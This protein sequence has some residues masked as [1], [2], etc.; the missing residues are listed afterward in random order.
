MLSQSRITRDPAFKLHN[1]NMKVDGWFS[2]H[3]LLL[4]MIFLL[5]LTGLIIGLYVKVFTHKDNKH[6]LYLGSNNQHSA[7]ST[8][9]SFVNLATYFSGYHTKEN[10]YTGV[11]TL[12]MTNSSGIDLRVVDSAGTP[13]SDANGPVLSTVKGGISSIS[14]SSTGGDVILQYKNS[15]SDNYLL[16]LEVE[17]S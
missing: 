6:L 14:F 11:F 17:P 4:I 9:S 2:Q 7:L 12:Q 8:S 15:A 3:H 1:D 10:P 16:R 5:I 13:I